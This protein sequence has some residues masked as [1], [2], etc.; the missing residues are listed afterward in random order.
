VGSFW[1]DAI[2]WKSFAASAGYNVNRTP[3]PG[4]VLHDPYSAP[5]YGHVAIV[6]RV[7]PDGS[8]FISEMNYAGWNII[9][10]RTVSAGEVGSYSYIH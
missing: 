1:G 7:N 2:T 6:E 5:P 4:A 9:S 3:A 8:I 10:T